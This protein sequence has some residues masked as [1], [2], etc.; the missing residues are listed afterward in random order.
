MDADAMREV[1]TL[2]FHALVAQWESPND[3]AAN[4]LR[5][6]LSGQRVEA[7]A[8]TSEPPATSPPTPG[9]VMTPAPPAA[10]P[11]M[12]P[13]VPAPTLAPAPT[14]V[15][16]PT[17]RPAAWAESEEVAQIRGQAKFGPLCRRL[18]GPF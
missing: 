12:P 14:P 9:T 10:L 15:A 16:P 11:L 3:A 6:A 13:P 8:A 4:A 1:V 5:L 7:P 2:N 17:L 18:A